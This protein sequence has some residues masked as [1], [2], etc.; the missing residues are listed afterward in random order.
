MKGDDRQKEVL[1]FL[2][3]FLS[4]FVA[5]LNPLTVEAGRGGYQSG[6]N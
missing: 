5:M 1:T 3:I 2:F 6:M 4:V